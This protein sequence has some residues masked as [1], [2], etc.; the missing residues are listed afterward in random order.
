MH[1]QGPTTKT[2]NTSAA[3]QQWSRLLN[4]VFRQEL[5]VLVEKSGIPV[6]AIISTEDLA[7]LRRFEADQAAR[8]EALAATRAA[9]QDVPDE[10][11]EREVHRA[12]GQARERSR[13]TPQPTVA[14]AR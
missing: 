1:P 11:L 3:R 4:Q 6:A 13:R 8:F 7:R 9:F 12:F 5:R 2:I 10:E 14:P